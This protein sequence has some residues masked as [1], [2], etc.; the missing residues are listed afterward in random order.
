MT[1]QQLKYAV[2]VAECGNVTAAS[3]KVFISQPSLTAA[4][5]ELEREIGISIFS[6][7]NK[8]VIVTNEKRMSGMELIK[9]LYSRVIKSMGFQGAM[10]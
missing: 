8:G 1:I 6:R 5:H 7:T 3:Q 9:R 2:A 4:I 10:V